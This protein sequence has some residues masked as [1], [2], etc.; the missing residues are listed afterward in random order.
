MILIQTVIIA[1]VMFGTIRSEVDMT[2]SSMASYGRM[3]AKVIAGRLISEIMVNDST[4]SADLERFIDIVMSFDARIACVVVSDR[5]RNVL[6]GQINRTWVDYEG[7]RDAALVQLVQGAEAYRKFKSVAVAI[8]S[9]GQ[10]IGDIRIIFSLVPL[11]KQIL[12]SVLLWMSAGI[13]LAGLGVA[14]AFIISKKITDP[15]G[16]VAGA[17]KRVEDGDLEQRVEIRTKDEV[18]DMAHAF[19]KMVEGL[20]EREFIKNTFSK[21]VS[22]QVAERILKEKDFLNLKGEKRVVTVLFADIR[23]FTPLAESLPPEKVLDILNRYFSKMVDIVFRYGGLLNKFIG[24]A[25][26]VLYNAP[27]DQRYHELRA[28]LTGIEMQKEI[29]RINEERRQHGDI[30]VNM[31][32]GINTGDAVAGN[33]GSELRLEYTVI[34]A[35]VNLAQRIE[36]H[37]AKGQLLI[38]E[39]TYNAVKDHVEV[40][41]LEPMQVKGISEPVQLYAVINADIPEDFNEIA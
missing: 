22:S 33:V 13:A 7:T 30:Q 34:G 9:D 32:I 2:Y 16:S 25:I 31:G 27:L 11:Q 21:Y 15:L 37:T 17:M 14:G 4:K 39:S 12:L 26:M 5:N 36:S 19:N 24:D 28:I 1:T 3:M 20:K 41:R 35:G 40:V 29:A 10:H 6:A 18:A 23:G 8:D 38:S